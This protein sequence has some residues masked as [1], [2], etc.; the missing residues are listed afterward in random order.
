[1][2][3]D[4]QKKVLLDYLTKV[5]IDRGVTLHPLLVNEVVNSIYEQ[6]N[7]SPGE[8]FTFPFRQNP[9]DVFDVQGFNK[10]FEVLKLD[11]ETLF[12]LA[13]RARIEARQMLLLND[14]RM[15]GFQD[16]IHT[17]EIESDN[18][19]SRTVTDGIHELSL[20]IPIKFNNYLHRNI[21]DP[22][23]VDVLNGVITLPVKVPNTRIIDL[24]Y[25]SDNPSAATVETAAN[26]SELVEDQSASPLSSI[27]NT[28]ASPWVHNVTVNT[29]RT[30]LNIVLTL[31]LPS[32]EEINR[33][34]IEGVP[35]GL[36]TATV[37]V[38][39]IADNFLPV[40]VLNASQ[41]YVIMPATKCK[42]IRIT[43][44][45]TPYEATTTGSKFM[46]GIKSI[47]LSRNVY[48]ASGE[49]VITDINPAL[50]GKSL[51]SVAM[52]AT[53]NTPAG[54]AVDYAL[55]L[56]GE[57]TFTEVDGQSLGN[58]VQF[59]ISKEFDSSLVK[60]KRSTFPTCPS[61]NHINYKRIEPVDTNGVSIMPTNAKVLDRY[62]ELW[63]LQNCFKQIDNPAYTTLEI[64]DA[65][66]DFK[67]AGNLV[68]A[69]RAP[70]VISGQPLR[71]SGSSQ[72][73]LLPTSLAYQSIAATSAVNPVD[74][75]KTEKSGVFQVEYYKTTTPSTTTVITH[76][77]SLQAETNKVFVSG[78]YDQD[79]SFKVS[80]L[81]V[82]DD[83]VYIKPETLLLHNPIAGSK[84]ITEDNVINYSLNLYHLN[85]DNT[86][87]PTLPAAGTN[88]LYGQT[89]Y[90]NFTGIFRT[91]KIDLYETYVTFSPNVVGLV[92]TTPITA[93]VEAGEY[94]TLRELQ[95]G[96]LIRLEKET[97]LNTVMA[98]TY[99]LSI[100]TKPANGLLDSILTTRVDQAHLV[101]PD[102]TSE[103][104]FPILF[105]M[106][107]K[108]KVLSSI[109]VVNSPL[110]Y[111]TLS[112]F[113]NRTGKYDNAYYST[114][115]ID[116]ALYVVV[117]EANS[118]ILHLDNDN[119]YMRIKFMYFDKS[120][121]NSQE[122][123][124]LRIRM[125]S[126]A[127]QQTLNTPEVSELKFKIRYI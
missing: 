87:Y 100:A 63:P 94:A 73:I 71:K 53:G 17:L 66:V 95:S 10:F 90:L 13:I 60:A 37:E 46:F 127:N 79:I 47:K 64:Q 59:S 22:L 19:N 67:S 105:N 96:N 5:A 88:P 61:R 116:G 123:I 126:L 115:E 113:L 21:A 101:S 72:Y 77:C 58:F 111:R 99:L 110:K 107:S 81:G 85:S 120:E 25:L 7:R 121:Y 14:V 49:V 54:T 125:E 93:D 45:N 23:D 104:K 3:G 114:S 51:I 91:P 75:M 27:A 65:I 56:K 26:V 18:F 103:E 8:P 32:I 109:S 70:L 4:L 43:I 2:I 83:S 98:G 30:D 12:K 69:I 1:M 102:A 35:G 36:R 48:G 62:I 92:L 40:G 24:S 108:Q 20:S 42:K 112:S 38:A 80:Y 78:V 124:D 9:R 86:I 15:R 6:S 50:A 117:P 41:R 16:R 28:S 31:S 89:K 122:T 97:R 34:D 82:I 76:L 118:Q 11:V 29:Q 74:R 39:L 57:D 33:V 84:G 55:R 119:E 44:N 52:E 68:S 106:A